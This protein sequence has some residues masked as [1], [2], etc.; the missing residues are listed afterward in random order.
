[1]GSPEWWLN[2]E[3]VAVYMI[4]KAEAVLLYN[5]HLGAMNLGADDLPF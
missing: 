4:M 2:Y 3:I 5:F 1:M